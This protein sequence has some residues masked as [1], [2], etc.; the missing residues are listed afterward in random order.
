MQRKNYI[1]FHE[2]NILKKIIDQKKSFSKVSSSK[3]E[4]IT[5]AWIKRWMIKRIKR[6]E[7]LEKLTTLGP[8]FIHNQLYFK[9]KDNVINIKKSNV[10]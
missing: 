10:D 3:V 2:K 6:N 4:N 7:T 8:D 5:S 9:I 1:F